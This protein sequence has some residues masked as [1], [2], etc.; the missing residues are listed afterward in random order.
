VA[1]STP[2]AAAAAA[3]GS[4]ASRAADPAAGKQGAGQTHAAGD[5][6]NKAAL[7]RA[8][9]RQHKAEAASKLVELAAP[10]AC[11]LAKGKAKAK[12]E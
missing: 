10:K 4:A 7:K 3:A 8:K 9:R 5:K 2:T 12:T 1:G 6:R 11:K